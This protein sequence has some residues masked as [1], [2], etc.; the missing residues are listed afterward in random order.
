[1]LNMKSTEFAYKF[2]IGFEREKSKITQ[3]IKKKKTT[4]NIDPLSWLLNFYQVG[5]GTF[6]E[7]KCQ[8]WTLLIAE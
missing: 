5:L 8:L 6:V 4:H 3:V 7:S 2:N 1:M